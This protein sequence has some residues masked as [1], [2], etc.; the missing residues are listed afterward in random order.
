MPKQLEN[1][2]TNIFYQILS[3]INFIKNDIINFCN[4]Q[5]INHQQITLQEKRIIKTY[6]VTKISLSIMLIKKTKKIIMSRSKD[7]EEFIYFFYI[8]EFYTV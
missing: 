8:N 1:R 3:K 4:K 6:N 2:S 5:Y 7:V